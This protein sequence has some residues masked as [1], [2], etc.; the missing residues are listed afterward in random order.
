[1]ELVIIASIEP[2]QE[3]NPEN[4]GSISALN[5]N[6]AVQFDNKLARIGRK[7]VSEGCSHKWCNILRNE[8]FQKFSDQCGGGCHESF[9]CWELSR[10]GIII[11]LAWYGIFCTPFWI[12]L[13]FFVIASFFTDSSSCSSQSTTNKLLPASASTCERACGFVRTCM[14]VILS[15]ARSS[16]NSACPV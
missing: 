11:Y 8:C 3:A 5:P 15:R 2:D 12:I 14:S 13:P 9:A 7:M 6:D 16:S 1:M 10:C 4:S